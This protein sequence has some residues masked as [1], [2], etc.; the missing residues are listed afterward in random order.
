MSHLHL[1][2]TFGE[3]HDGNCLV[4]GNPTILAVAFE[5]WSVPEQQDEK[6]QEETG[7]TVGVHDEISGHYCRECGKLTALFLNRSNRQ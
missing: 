7:G 4:C 6:A 1:N 5:E 2:S 3:T